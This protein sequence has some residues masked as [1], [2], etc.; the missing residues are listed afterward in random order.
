MGTRTDWG[1]TAR[2]ASFTLKAADDGPDF[3][4]SLARSGWSWKYD[5]RIARMGRV[6]PRDRQTSRPTA[7]CANRLKRG[8]QDLY[9]NVTCDDCYK[10]MNR[11][12]GTTRSY[13]TMFA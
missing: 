1:R 11:L 4:Q 8:R 5:L 12:L 6:S 9:A 3:E 2:Y 10:P 7:R 13:L